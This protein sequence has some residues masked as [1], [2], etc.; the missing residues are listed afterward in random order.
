M[1]DTESS[2]EEY[3][4]KSYYDKPKNDAEDASILKEK[5]RDCVNWYLKD[6]KYY[7]SQVYCIRNEMKQ[8]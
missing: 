8:D 5:C 2:M 1:A 7:C 4:P 3:K 6:G